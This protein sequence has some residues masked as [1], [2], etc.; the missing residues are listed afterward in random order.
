MEKVSRQTVLKLL[1]KN[2]QDL[3]AFKSNATANGGKNKY[4]WVK[5]GAGGKLVELK[6]NKLD[7][8]GKL[9]SAKTGPQTSSGNSTFFLTIAV[10]ST[11]FVSLLVIVIYLEKR[12][13]EKKKMEP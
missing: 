1:E 7:L 3:E 11:I 2:I 12:K 10:I 4:A 9:F 6:I 5:L 8:E 13:S